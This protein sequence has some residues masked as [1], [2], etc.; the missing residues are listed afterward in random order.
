MRSAVPVNHNVS[1]EAPFRQPRGV[2][3]AAMPCH[4]SEPVPHATAPATRWPRS[5][6]GACQAHAGGVDLPRRGQY[7]ALGEYLAPGMTVVHG[8]TRLPVISA[9]DGHP[10]DART[11]TAHRPER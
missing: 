11:L 10:A 7:R 1:P 9:T 2:L 8:G 6:R 5:G 3:S 4:R